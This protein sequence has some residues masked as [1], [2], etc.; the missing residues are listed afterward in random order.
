MGK[1]KFTDSSDLYT[2]VTK[3]WSAAKLNKRKKQVRAMIA[4][5][6]EKIGKRHLAILRLKKELENLDQI[7]PTEET[8][9]CCPVSITLPEVTCNNSVCML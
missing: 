3:K 6:E 5:H 9:E 4:N 2:P 8:K 7:K 1:N